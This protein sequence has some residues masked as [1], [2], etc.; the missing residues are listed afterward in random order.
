LCFL[1]HT[2]YRQY[3]LVHG[4]RDCQLFSLRTSLNIYIDIERW[5][6]RA[7]LSLIICLCERLVKK[8]LKNIVKKGQNP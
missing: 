8:S 7:T 2:K 5:V 4:N 6:N 3:I 1:H